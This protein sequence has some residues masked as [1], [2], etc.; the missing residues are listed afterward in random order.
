VIYDDDEEANAVDLGDE[1][2]DSEW[3]LDSDNEDELDNELYDTKF[4]RID[5]I[6]YVR[7]Q[8][9]NLQQQNPGHWQ[10]ILSYLDETAQNN[11]QQFFQQA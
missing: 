9:D 6:L 8:L 4:D 2:D 1:S 3:D 10:T 11:L 7:D 5:E